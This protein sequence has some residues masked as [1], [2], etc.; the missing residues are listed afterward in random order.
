[1]NILNVYTGI[2]KFIKVVKKTNFL[3]VIFLSSFLLIQILESNF[4]AFAETNQ[5]TSDS[6]RHYNI[7]NSKLKSNKYIEAIEE[8][9]KAIQLYQDFSMAYTNRGI[10]RKKLGYFQDAIKDYNKALEINSTDFNAYYNR[11][12]AKFEIKEY[13]DAI[14]DYDQAILINSRHS[15]FYYNRALSRLAVKDK[16][17]ACV[18][19]AKS[20]SMNNQKV[21]DLII[22]DFKLVCPSIFKSKI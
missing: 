20:L 2:N 9:S 11:G 15:R 19:F 1:M 21:I 22:H 6:V 4:K 8:Y 10:A 17:N 13:R 7:G 3:T 12:L 18:D 14:N 5:Y 16:K